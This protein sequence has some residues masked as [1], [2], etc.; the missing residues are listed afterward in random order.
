MHSTASTY[1]ARA[2]S[3]LITILASGIYY[4]QM[5]NFEEAAD[6]NTVSFEL[7]LFPQ[8]FRGFTAVLAVTVVHCSLVL[9]IIASFI[10]TTKLT[11]VGDH[12]QSIAQ[13]ISPATESFLTKSSYATDKEDAKYLK[14]AHREKEVASIQQLSDSE[15]RVGLLSQLV[16]RRS[17]SGS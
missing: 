17:R 16:Q 6:V 7:F 8:C 13:I 3:A 4:E 15:E 2:L 12:W 5:A 10:A 1:A 14:K 11:I 9:F